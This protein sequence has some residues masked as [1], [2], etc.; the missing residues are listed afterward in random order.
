M[1]EEQVLSLN[2]TAKRR[3]VSLDGTKLEMLAYEEVP[4]AASV[5]LHLMMDALQKKEKLTEDSAQALSIQ[6]VQ[7]V[8]DVLPKLPKNIDDKLSDVNRIDIIVAF[9]TAAETPAPSAA[10][11]PALS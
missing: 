3:V 6:L 11:E 1:A 7:A 10:L 5:R 2:T 8:R 4:L 9:L